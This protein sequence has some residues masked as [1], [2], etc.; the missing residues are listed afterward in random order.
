MSFYE[1]AWFWTGIF[2]IVGSLGGI[3]IREWLTSKSQ[4]RLERL[5][6]H[7]ADVLNA[8]RSLYSFISSAYALYPPNDPP[9]DF[10]ELMRY[11][12]FK[13][14][15][16]N[17]ILFSASIRDQLQVLES[18]YDCLR[19]SDLIPAKPFED[20]FEEDFVKILQKLESLVVKQTDRVFH[21]EG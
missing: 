2:G 19:D 10:R 15:K 8:Y 5:K 3:V 13:H 9:Q 14:V 12:Y 21:L 7:E 1:Q 17:M 16:P 4:L 11:S 18:Q 6:L 20:F